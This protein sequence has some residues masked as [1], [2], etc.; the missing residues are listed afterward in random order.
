MTDP[1]AAPRSPAAIPHE[2]RKPGWAWWL[3]FGLLCLLLISAINVS[4]RLIPFAWTSLFGIA[5]NVWGMVGLVG[6][7]TMKPIGPRWQWLICLSLTV[8]QLATGVLSLLSV[9]LSSGWTQAHK[10]A[11]IVLIGQLLILPLIS[12]LVRYVFDFAPLWNPTPV[13]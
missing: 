4:F 5:L 13:D 11:L 7:I 3:Y 6:F 1:Y 8:V 2:R 12:A 9:L 10:V